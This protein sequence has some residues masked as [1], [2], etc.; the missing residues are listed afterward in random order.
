MK[1]IFYPF[2]L[3][4]FLIGYSTAAHA[5]AAVPAGT[6]PGNAPLIKKGQKLTYMVLPAE[7]NTW[8]YEVSVDGKPYIRQLSIPGEPGNRGFNSKREAE[9]TAKLVIGKIQRNIIP[10][11]VTGQELS[12]I[13]AAV[14]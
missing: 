14:R 3:S 4:A 10:P 11:A 1:K 5:Q 8:G 13:R 6:T 9:E 2:L 7:G 12:Q